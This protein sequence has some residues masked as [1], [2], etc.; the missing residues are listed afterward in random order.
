MLCIKD[1]VKSLQQQHS[2]N[3]ALYKAK[4]SLLSISEAFVKW[5]FKAKLVPD[6]GTNIFQWSQQEAIL[7]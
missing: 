4:V 3:Q 2:V 5:G 1:V 7:F 6:P